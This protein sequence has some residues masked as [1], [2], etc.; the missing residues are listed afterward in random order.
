MRAIMRVMSGTD[1]TVCT[2]SIGNMHKTAINRSGGQVIS[3]V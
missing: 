2:R 1:V 3:A